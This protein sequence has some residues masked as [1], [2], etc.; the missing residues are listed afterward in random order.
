MCGSNGPPVRSNLAETRLANCGQMLG[1]SSVLVAMKEALWSWL[2]ALGVPM[3]QRSASA[4]G[5][6]IP[7]T[8]KIF[9][10]AVVPDSSL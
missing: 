6:S 2:P 7:T 9:P 8:S 5:E 10:F 4:N 3:D 1:G